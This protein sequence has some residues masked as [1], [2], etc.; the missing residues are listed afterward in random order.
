MPKRPRTR[1]KRANTID[2]APR[3]RKDKSTPLNSQNSTNHD[4][5]ISML[6][7][8]WIQLFDKM[9]D[10]DKDI[11]T[12]VLDAKAGGDDKNKGN[13]ISRHRDTHKLKGGMLEDMEY[14]EDDALLI[15]VCCIVVYI[16]L[17][18]PDLLP[19]IIQI[20]LRVL[21]A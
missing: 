19:E 1:R 5:R 3:G 18:R 10:K 4:H 11:M 9:Q 16:L 14:G 13:S 6:R 7:E 2:D 15:F 12:K 17:V 20:I 21:Y 8:Q